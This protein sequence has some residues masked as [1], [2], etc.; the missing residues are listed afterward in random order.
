MVILGWSVRVVMCICS[1]SVVRDAARI[2]PVVH[3]GGFVLVGNCL[4]W[5]DLVFF[6]SE[7]SG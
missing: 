2:E 4:G 3:L 1:L 6:G 5:L 7:L